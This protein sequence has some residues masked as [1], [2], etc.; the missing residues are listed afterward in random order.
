MATGAAIACLLPL[1]AVPADAQRIA[2]APAEIAPETE[3]FTVDLTLDTEGATVMGVDVVFACDPA[4]VRVDSV[5]V[6][7]WFTSASQPWFFWSGLIDQP[8]A[9]SMVRV[10]GSVMTTGRAGAGTLAV[11]HFTAVGVGY[12]PLP[13]VSVALRDPLNNPVPYIRSDGL[14]V[15]APIPAG[16]TS[17]GALKALWR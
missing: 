10:T 14:V 12:C 13:I 2:F 5:T 9:V 1:C 8:F 4:V 15:I 3:A 7:G 17:F 16:T 11:L 6:G